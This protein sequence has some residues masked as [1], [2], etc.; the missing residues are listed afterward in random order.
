MCICFKI[1]DFLQ[2]LRFIEQNFFGACASDRSQWKL[3]RGRLLPRRLIRKINFVGAGIYFEP[4][5]TIE[6]NSTAWPEG[7]RAMEAARTNKVT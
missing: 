6:S 4:L 5:F 1:L 2:Y 3:S 7:T